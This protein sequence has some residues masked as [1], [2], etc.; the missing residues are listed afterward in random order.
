MQHTFQDNVLVPIFKGKAD[1]LTFEDGM[2]RN[3]GKKLSCIKSE[4]SADLIYTVTEAW[5]HAYKNLFRLKNI[6]V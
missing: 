4:K 6:W 3:F 5:N 2:S 1:C